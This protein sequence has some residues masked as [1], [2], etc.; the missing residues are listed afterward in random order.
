MEKQNNFYSINLI[1]QNDIYKSISTIVICQICNELKIEPKIS[2]CSENCQ[3]S[4]CGEC[5][6]KLNQCPICRKAPKWNNCLI[7]KQLLSTLDFKCDK[8]N[9]IVHFDD[10]KKHY[11]THKPDYYKKK[12]KELNEENKKLKTE[13]NKLNDENQLI[14]SNDQ[15]NNEVTNINNNSKKF[16]F[17]CR[18]CSYFWSKF[19][20]FYNIIFLLGCCALYSTYFIIINII[21]YIIIKLIGDRKKKEKNIIYVLQIIS[22]LIMLF[23]FCIIVVLFLVIAF[24]NITNNQKKCYFT[25]FFWFILALYWVLIFYL[26]L[27]FIWDDILLSNYSSITR[28]IFMYLFMSIG[29]IMLIVNFYYIS[30]YLIYGR[31]NIDDLMEIINYFRRI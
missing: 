26:S 5:A 3:Y 23:L 10:L 12:Y 14:N 20:N 16:K 4:V 19:I 1:V 9:K 18:F 30:D 7:L 8:C 31:I 11:D 24:G 13:T 2:S 27:G 29:S 25:C 22:S 15:L 17:H 28:I 6:K 21:I